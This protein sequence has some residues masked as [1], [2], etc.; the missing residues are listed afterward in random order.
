MGIFDSLFGGGLYSIT[1]ND[2]KKMTAN[3]GFVRYA[4][5]YLGVH[6]DFPRYF[7]CV[8]ELSAQETPSP[9]MNIY[10]NNSAAGIMVEPGHFC[11]SVNIKKIKNIEH[12]N[13][14][15]FSGGVLVGHFGAI[16]QET[17]HSIFIDFLDDKSRHQK[18][19]FGTTPAIKSEAYFAAFVKHLTGLI[20]IHDVFSPTKEN[21]DIKVCPF[22][23][24]TIKKAAILCR[25]CGRDIPQTEAPII[26]KRVCQT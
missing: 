15:V 23:A 22:C 9:I 6:N 3:A 14:Q 25:Y 2:A 5:R 26:I 8:A 1:E 20:E 11:F 7:E 12:G 16:L 13:Q 17:R 19:G 24:E 18:V 21:D 10:T 4:F